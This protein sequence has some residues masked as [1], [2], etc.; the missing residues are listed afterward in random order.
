[1]P[2]DGQQ[3]PDMIVSLY[4]DKGIRV[5]YLRIPYFS[6][7][8]QSDDPK[9][10]TLKQVKAKGGSGQDA[11]TDVAHSFLLANLMLRPEPQIA[12]IPRIPVKRNIKSPYNLHAYIYAGYDFCPDCYSEEV[13]IYFEIKLA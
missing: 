13:E 4:N 3:I 8:L 12:G 10:Y 7:D 6:T 2:Q 5:A 9:W 1:M 11:K